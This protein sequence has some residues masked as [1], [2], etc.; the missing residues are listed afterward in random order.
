M[1]G[2]VSVPDSWK[3]FKEAGEAAAEGRRSLGENGQAKEEGSSNIRCAQREGGCRRGLPRSLGASLSAGRCNVPPAEQ[4]Q[5][6][7]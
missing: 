1:G 3:A 2:S 4:A 6:Q 7:E 5:R